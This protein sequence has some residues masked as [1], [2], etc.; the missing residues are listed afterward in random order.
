MGQLIRGV[1]ASSVNLARYRQKITERLFARQFKRLAEQWQEIAQVSGD[2]YFV[3]EEFFLPHPTADRLSRDPTVVQML[4]KL[5]K[6]M[7]VLSG[8]YYAPLAHLVR[9]QKILETREAKVLGFVHDL[10]AACRFEDYFGSLLFPELQHV[11]KDEIS[12]R[13]LGDA[14]YEE[15]FYMETHPKPERVIEAQQIVQQQ[16]AVQLLVTK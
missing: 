4:N 6:P 10:Y 13:N 3:V 5:R 16:L 9:H 7:Y 1:N 14:Q 11:L 8:E 15:F 2:S 12:I